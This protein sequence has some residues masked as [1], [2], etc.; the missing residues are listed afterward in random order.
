MAVRVAEKFTFIHI[1]KTAGLSI[2]RWLHDNCETKHTA[3]PH[4][5]FDRLPKTW[6]D[7]TVAIVRNPWDRLVSLYNHY[8]HYIKLNGDPLGLMPLLA[9]GFKSYV[10]KHSMTIFTYKQHKSKDQSKCWLRQTQH[11][12]IDSTTEILRFETL[13]AD[14]HS[15]CQR[16]QLGYKPLPVINKNHQRPPYQDYYD[17]ETKEFVAKAWQDDINHFRYD[18]EPSAQITI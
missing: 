4:M 6:Q 8:C 16:Q 9:A 5:T 10:M 13:A 7:S 18:F 12:F 3:R 14:W 15:F 17:D 11:Q 1:P 2:T